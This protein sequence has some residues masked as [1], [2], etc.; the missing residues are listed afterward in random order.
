MSRRVVIV[1]GGVAGLAAAQALTSAGDGPQV[2]LLEGSERVGGRIR[3]VPFGG[4]RLDVGP[5][6]LLSRAPGGVELCRSLGLGDDLVPCSDAGAF[7]WSRGKLRA[8]PAGLLAGLPAGPRELLRSRILSPAGIGRASLDFVLPA[9]APQGDEAIGA[10]VRR[11]LGAQVLARLIDP[12]LGGIN[13][14][15]CDDL[16]VAAG[17]PYLATA[18]RAN[19][20]LVRG[21]RA[22]MPSPPP[23]VVRSPVFLSLR[24][25]L[26]TLVG[27]L[28][29]ALDGT[30]VRVNTTVRTIERSAGGLAVVLDSGERLDADGVILATP[31]A[32][33]AEVVRAA[34]P[35][36]ADELAG[37]STA[38]VALVALAYPKDSVPELGGTGFLV[39]RD[40]DLEITA[41]TWATAKW[42][43]LAEGAT[44][45]I[46]K[47][48]L[49]RA[50]E[51]GVVDEPDDALIARAR[52]ALQRTMTITEAPADALVVRHHDAFPQYAV[53]H[54]DRV[55][56]I[57][58]DLAAALPGLHVAGNSY[59]GVG[60]PACI[61]SGRAA[62]ERLLQAAPTPAPDPQELNSR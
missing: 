62:A 35:D 13:A 46:L 3:T 50:G 29:D 58:D 23:G 47:C 18:A 1:G 20:S 25:G 49:G 14:G 34:A 19:R 55:A 2:T 38:S 43:H 26:E 32:S 16:S 24:G 36:A 12:L 52:R 8:L 7:I 10:L 30:D 54:L 41:C 28:A 17:A 45:T 37:I 39:A 27:A 51:D 61:T 5:D 56:R 44:H 57:E 15:H 6:A 53:G 11:R 40:E 21:L 42:P 59:R 48:S 31:A 9:N 4:V 22:T 60:V 33:A